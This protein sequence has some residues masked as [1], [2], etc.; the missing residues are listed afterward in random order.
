[1]MASTLI[2]LRRMVMSVVLTQ[3]FAAALSVPTLSGCWKPLPEAQ[4]PGEV[5]N[6][7]LSSGGLLRSYLVFVP[8]NYNPL[9][10]TP[11]ILSYHGGTQTAEDQLRLDQLTN[12]EFNTEAF[13]IYPQGIN[14]CRSPCSLRRSPLACTHW[15]IPRYLLETE[16]ALTERRRTP[17]KACRA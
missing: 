12:P 15:R 2:T 1:M 9:V 11:V 14:V 3:A 5:A 10:P 16:K 8:P 17:G 6:I 13:V 7:T 4:S